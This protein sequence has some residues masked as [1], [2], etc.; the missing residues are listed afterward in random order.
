MAIVLLNNI[1]F[2]S[3]DR[4]SA[5]P[6]FSKDGIQIQDIQ[7]A[8]TIR[9]RNYP[10][11]LKYASQH[12]YEFIDT[13]W[14]E[15]GKDLE[16]KI[17]AAIDGKRLDRGDRIHDVIIKLGAI[18]IDNEKFSF[19]TSKNIGKIVRKLTEK[20]QFKT[21][22]SAALG[23]ERESTFLG[24][25]DLKIEVTFWPKSQSSSLDDK[26]YVSSMTVQ[27]MNQRLN[28]TADDTTASLVS[29]FCNRQFEDL[30][31]QIYH[32][33]GDS[34]VKN[35][36]AGYIESAIQRMVPVNILLTR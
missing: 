31:Y 16:Q 34:S 23:L 1:G 25:F 26:I 28:S 5:R 24:E 29:R 21:T 32:M 7:T 13:V 35:Q 22:S 15:G 2:G 17:Q 6:I 9:R 14:N 30:I 12:S 20:I 18:D 27:I 36:W 8:P 10:N 33:D 3:L 4:V 19:G 11:A